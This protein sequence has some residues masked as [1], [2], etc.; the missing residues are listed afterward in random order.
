VFFIP[1]AKMPYIHSSCS[2]CSYC[3]NFAVSALQWSLVTNTERKMIPMVKNYSCPFCIQKSSR[4]SNMEVHIRR[5]HHDMHLAWNNPYRAINARSF[6]YPNYNLKSNNSPNSMVFNDGAS[7]WRQTNR[8]GRE[9]DYMDH[10]INLW[11][12]IIWI[13]LLTS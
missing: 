11:K 10:I 5:R 12:V 3:S 4:R 2:Y 8:G 7:V 6:E 13:T 9:G 1:V